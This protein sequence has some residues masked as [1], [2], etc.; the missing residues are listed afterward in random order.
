[1]F[2]DRA[3]MVSAVISQ[4]SGTF[5]FV[6]ALKNLKTKNHKGGSM[7]MIGMTLGNFHHR[8]HTGEETVNDQHR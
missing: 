2:P 1:M 6:T 7:M 5:R 4:E 8:P 3:R